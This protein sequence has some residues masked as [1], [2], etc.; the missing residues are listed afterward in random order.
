MLIDGSDMRYFPFNESYSSLVDFEMAFDYA[1]AFDFA[2][3]RQLNF[4]FI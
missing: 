1:I 2:N 3:S 4:L